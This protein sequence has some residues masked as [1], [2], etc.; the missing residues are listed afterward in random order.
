MRDTFKIKIFIGILAVILVTSLVYM[1]VLNPKNKPPIRV[2]ILHSLSGSLAENEK[3][4]VDILLMSVHEVNT[5]GGIFGRKIEAIVADSRSDP[6]HA[7]QEAERLIRDE[8]VNVIFGCGTSLCRKAIKTVVEKYESLLFYPLHYEGLEQ[9]KNI[10]YTGITPNQQIVSGLIWSLNNFGPR[11]HLIGSD[12]TFPYISNYIIRDVANIKKATLV[13]ERYLPLRSDN[14]DTIIAEIAQLQPDVLM[15]SIRGQSNKSF[16]SKRYHAGLDHIPVLSFSITETELALIPPG[17]RKNIY[18]VWSYFQ[19]INTPT[20][21]IFVAKVKK[22]LGHETVISDPME[23]SYIGFQLW[24]QAVESAESTNAA[25]VS[26]AAR[27]MTLNAPEGII[28]VDGRNLHLSKKIRVGR[29][30][31]DGQFDII[32]ESQKNI[33]PIPYPSYRGRN[34]WTKILKELSDKEAAH[35]IQ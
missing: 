5:R 19:S 9:S 16:F 34:Q 14:F 24:I 33:R 15:N 17:H 32:W 23:A 25:M 12:D 2:G 11:L 21:H 6:A 3:P 29:A 13:A 22:H 27:E 10:I 31:T 1:S 20:N 28:S 35:E 18:A 30:R 4:L 7:A 26:R 8:K